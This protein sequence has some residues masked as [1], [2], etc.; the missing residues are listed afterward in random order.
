MKVGKGKSGNTVDVII[1][2]AIVIV[3]GICVIALIRNF[4]GS[5]YPAPVL[6]EGKDY[7]IQYSGDNRYTI[8]DENGNTIELE[9]V[10]AEVFKARNGKLYKFVSGSPYKYVG[11]YNEK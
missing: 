2:L 10:T 1:I 8:V 6:E 9:R 11:E 7:D 3:V 4:T 5:A